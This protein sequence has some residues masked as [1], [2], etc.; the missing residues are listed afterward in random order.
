MLLVC[1][2]AE[3]VRAEGIEPVRAEGIEPV[4]AGGIEPVKAEGIEP[5]TAQGIEP[6]TAQ[7]IEPVKAQG[8]KKYTPKHRQSNAKAKE[9]GRVIDPKGQGLSQAQIDAMEAQR[10]LMWNATGGGMVY[11]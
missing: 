1:L 10:Q 5:V 7:G 3:P 8:I 2:N 11:R 6:V 4:K 9:R